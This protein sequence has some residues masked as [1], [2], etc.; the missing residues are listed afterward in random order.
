L[1]ELKNYFLWSQSLLHGLTWLVIICIDTL[2]RFRS[3][4]MAIRP[5]VF[6]NMD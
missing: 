4:S 6:L 1:K 3:K 2:N 5:K